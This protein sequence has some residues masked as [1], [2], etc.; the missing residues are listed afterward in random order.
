VVK[1]TSENAPKN[2]KKKQSQSRTA[3][4]DQC[5]RLAQAHERAGMKA[6]RKRSLEKPA[7]NVGPG[8]FSGRGAK[9]GRPRNI[10][11]VVLIG[12][13]GAG[14]SSVGRALG[15]QLGWEFEDLDE[16][17]ERRERRKVAEIFRESGEA[18]FRKTEH[19][20]LKELLAELRGGT[21]KIV[22]LGGG[23]FAQESNARLLAAANALTIFLDADAQE[24]WKRCGDQEGIERPLLGSLAS[25]CE[26]YEA[27]RP[28]YLKAKLRQETSGKTVE[29]IA[30]EVVEVLG[31]K[32]GSGRRGETQ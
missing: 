13:M 21:G 16:R 14:K 29:Q 3:H 24:L 25:F 23:A 17:I 18:G 10:K 4:R 19:A 5:G 27:R 7:S 12:F 30:A 2:N 28:H 8:A 26:L 32:P 22:A 11:A 15:K 1:S 31:L 9:R 20:A 6:R